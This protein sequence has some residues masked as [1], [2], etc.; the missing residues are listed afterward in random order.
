MEQKQYSDK[1]Q[2]NK[3]KYKILEAEN[4]KTG[5]K[6]IK[7]YF[8]I[9]KQKGN[10]YF[11]NS[12]VESCSHV[13][14]RNNSC[15][16]I[17]FHIINE[18]GRKL[19]YY[20]YLPKKLAVNRSTYISD[21]IPVANMHCGMRDKPLVPYDPDSLRNRLPIIGTV[22][23][24]AVNRSSLNLGSKNFNLLD[25]RRQWRTTYRDAFKKPSVIPV[26]NAGIASDMAKASRRR[27]NAS[28]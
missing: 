17:P 2:K 25:R 4:K 10:P 18:K 16:A 3:Y 23:G 22:S 1:Y 9:Q 21:F 12:K 5:E 14:V 7:S 8:K 6:I 20:K 27:L 26:T 24:A 13:L 15:L 28:V 11:N 19:N